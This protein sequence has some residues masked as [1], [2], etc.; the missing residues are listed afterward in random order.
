[1]QALHLYLFLFRLFRK[2]SSKKNL[3]V[4][5]VVNYVSND[6]ET[7][8]DFFVDFTSLLVLPFQIVIYIYLLY[9]YLGISVIS[10]ILVL[11]I[12]SPLNY[13]S[14][15][16]CQH[17][18]EKQ[19]ELKAKR[20]TITSDIIKS[21]KLLKLY[22]WELPF[23]QK[24]T[25]V[26]KEE[27]NTLRKMYF[28]DIILKVVWSSTHLLM[29][30]AA[31]ATYILIDSSHV[32]EIKTIFVSLALFDILK[33]VFGLIPQVVMEFIQFNVS[34]RRVL[35]FLNSEELTPYV[36]Q[37]VEST[38]DSVVILE[39]ASFL[40]DK[41]EGYILK[42]LN[43]SIKKSSLVA[44]VGKVGAGKSSLLSAII[45]EMHKSEG[46]DESVS[47]FENL[48][49]G[50][51]VKLIN[52]EEYEVGEVKWSH[53]WIYLK[54]GSIKI[55]FS[56]LILAI[57]INV[58][59]LGS[60][61]YLSQ[62]SKLHLSTANHIII[63]VGI[64]VV[65]ISLTA[66]AGFIAYFAAI[67][68]SK[69]IHEKLLKKVLKYPLTFFESHPL[70]R[71]LN[72]FSRDIAGIDTNIP[73]FL[74]LA[75][76]LLPYYPLIYGLIGATSLSFLF[77][78]I[79][80]FIIYFLIA[81]TYTW[82]SR[83]LQRLKSVTNSPVLNFISESYSGMS[84]IRAYGVRERFIQEANERID[85]HFKCYYNQISLNRALEC[86]MAIVG[87]IILFSVSVSLVYNKNLISASIIG[88]VL[89]YTIDA[90]ISICWSIR[91]LSFL[92][93]NMVCM[94]RIK[95]YMDF[96]EEAEWDL[97]IENI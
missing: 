16:K 36:Q 48:K 70:G 41:N 82:T 46:E 2:S 65:I 30:C 25:K 35:K 90:V 84:S 67:K 38:D 40:W 64:I 49:E 13:Y 83:Q 12:L 86:L 7:I 28:F 52:E 18:Q 31:F 8:F 91:V 20:L 58:G 34:L 45:G 32:L 27:M 22:A 51:E 1:M 71:I 93:T 14:S 56:A 62:W 44:I 96:E 5:E 60:T 6:T 29:A 9:Q 74:L 95:E 33:N 59:S 21:I 92:E 72:R 53:Y 77:G 88:L 4:G 80:I 37:C 11:I 85:L 87:G 68:A 55:F 79:L 39:H 76:I 42:S 15:K 81:R 17:Y 10:C 97:S 3:N 69:S 50:K 66:I 54:S 57:L 89:N 61:V 23:L 47:E 43:L 75:L 63:Y 19:M 24:A 73:N 94:E 78:V 26:R